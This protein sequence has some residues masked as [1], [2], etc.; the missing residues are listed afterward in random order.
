[1]KHRSIGG[2][3]LVL[4]IALGGCAPPNAGASG[5]PGAPSVPASHGAGH[6]AAPISTPTP[7]DDGY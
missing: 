1:M 3:V 2:L 5:D 4:A 7:V 6:S